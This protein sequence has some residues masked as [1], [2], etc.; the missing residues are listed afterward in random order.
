MDNEAERRVLN[1]VVSG[2]SGKT[3]L[4]TKCGSRKVPEPSSDHIHPLC[5]SVSC[6][7]I[8]TTYTITE[9]HSRLDTYQFRR[10]I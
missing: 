6:I 3:R 5:D 4:L 8:S 2:V 1:K 10:M 9:C 7:N